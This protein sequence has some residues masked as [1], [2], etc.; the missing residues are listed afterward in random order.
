MSDITEMK[1]CD[2]LRDSTVI[3]FNFLTHPSKRIVLAYVQFNVR[4][5]KNNLCHV[6]IKDN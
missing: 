4:M 1:T 2:H 5:S 3:R 6:R